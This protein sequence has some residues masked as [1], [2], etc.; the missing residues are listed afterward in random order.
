MIRL[1]RISEA[2]KA[3]RCWCFIVIAALAGAGAASAQ[4]K[5]GLQLPPPFDPAVA[6]AKG[7]ALAAE[8]SSQKPLQGATNSGVLKVRDS[9][10]QTREIPVR[11]TMLVTETNWASVYQAGDAES[12]GYS[13]LEVIHR[14]NQPNEYILSGTAEAGTTN[15]RLRRLFGNQSM[16]PF[17]GTDFWAA[18]LG[19]EFLHWPRQSVLKQE[20][21]K[22]Q[23]C[24]VLESTNVE[25]GPGCY[26]RVVSWVDID[27]GGIVHA[28][29]YDANN[30]LFKQFDPKTVRKINGQWQVEEMEIR[31]RETGSQTRFLFKLE[32][33]G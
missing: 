18:D 32:P 31:N 12:P 13:R 11:F 5:S 19:L 22:S 25:P 29:A 16:T 6:G 27:T 30:R 20:L 3:A 17:A 15:T 14:Q 8:L 33:G 28:D 26:S 24:N 4:P 7:L 21:R 9:Q 10:G 1:P 2:R 23:S